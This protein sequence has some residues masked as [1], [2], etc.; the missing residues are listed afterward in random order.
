MI[1]SQSTGDRVFVVINY[2]I[3]TI[4]GIMFFFP[5]LYQLAISFSSA[6]AVSAHNVFVWPVD[7]TI[8]SYTKVFE[9]GKIIRN[10]L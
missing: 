6:Q 8:K 3:L 2:T 1:R 7:P 10:G 9:T 5:I 4:L